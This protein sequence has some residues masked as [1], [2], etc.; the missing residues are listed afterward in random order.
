MG[1]TWEEEVLAS[2][3]AKSLQRLEKKKGRR[4]RKG[5]GGKKRQAQESQICQLIPKESVS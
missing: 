3:V 2:L 5:R 1:K 4:R